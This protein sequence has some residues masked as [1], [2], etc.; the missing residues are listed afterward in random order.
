MRGLHELLLGT[1]LVFKLCKK[2]YPEKLSLSWSAG[3]SKFW[4]TR[5][6]TPSA[7]VNKSASSPSRLYFTVPI[8]PDNVG[9]PEL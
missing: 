2:T 6:T 1:P 4:A 5:L 7:I 8:A 3:D 9:V